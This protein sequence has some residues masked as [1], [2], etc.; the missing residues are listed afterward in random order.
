MIFWAPLLSGI[1]FGFAVAAPVGPMSLLCMN[2][3]LQQGFWAGLATGFG[4][5]LAD[6]GY[7]LVTVS[8]F[9]IVNDFTSAYAVPLRLSGSLVLGLLGARSLQPVESSSKPETSRSGIPY[10]LL[11]SFVL[12]LANP[13]TILSFAALSASLGTAV[14]SSWFLP[15]GIAAGSVC[16]WLLFTSIL[17]WISGK[18]PASFTRWLNLSSAVTLMLFSLYGILAALNGMGGTK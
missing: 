13:A 17:K 4:I 11:S 1:G 12:T 2:R 16:W 15:A 14:G 18:L 8:S 3:T 7:A 5:A 6:A 9:N 10:C